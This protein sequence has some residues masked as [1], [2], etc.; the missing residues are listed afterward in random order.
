MALNKLLTDLSI[1]SKLGKNPGLDNGLSDEQLKAKFDEAANIIKDFL[2]DYLIPEMEKTV[3]VD[4]L[5]KDI[6]DTTL[7]K[8]DKAANAAATGEAIRKISAFFDKVI[9]AGDYILDTDGRFVASVSG[10]AR[11]RIAGG[12]GVMQG[13]LFAL[14]VGSGVDIQLADG[15]TGKLR[16]DL[17]VVR[18]TRN[19]D[20]SISFELAAIAGTASTSSASDPVYN[21]GDINTVGAVRDFPLHRVR[22]NGVDIAGLDPMFE[23]QKTM[24]EYIRACIVEYAQQSHLEQ[25]AVLSAA[26]WSNAAPFVQTVTIPGVKEEDKP[27]VGPVY[28]ADAAT[29]KEQRKAWAKVTYAEAGA[30]SIT[31]TCDDAKPAMEITVQIEVNR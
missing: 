28:A 7:S 17:I 4:A 12:E 19:T 27:H 2:N 6:L 24:D 14:N 26:G 5:L 16:N 30:G 20:N 21:T 29:R 15:S 11:V 1:I 23:T 18:A 25:E 8:S 9:N 13:N 10:D 3:D 22:F 31:F